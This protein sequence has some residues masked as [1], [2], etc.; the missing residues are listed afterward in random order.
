MSIFEKWNK[1]VDTEALAKEVKELEKGNGGNYEE[2]PYGTYEVKVE[3][4]ELKESS[5]GN[6]MLSV[7][8]KVLTGEQKGRFIF[9]NQVVMQPFQIHIANGFLKSLEAEVE[10]DFNGNYEDYNN[11]ILDIHEEIDG[12]LEY[13]LEYGENKKGYA[14]Y[15]ILEVYD[16]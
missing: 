2:V 3:K 12:K 8:F 1:T 11:M 14:T 16:V 4:M 6:P 15:K 7:W 5:N 9:M 10:V 13:L